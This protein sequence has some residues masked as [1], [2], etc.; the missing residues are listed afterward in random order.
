MGI[1]SNS[2]NNKTKTLT[3]KY[4]LSSHLNMLKLEGGTGFIFKP[5]F[6]RFWGR[7]TGTKT[8]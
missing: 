1:N 8:G 6:Y 2:N 7:K 3:P 5:V 4:S